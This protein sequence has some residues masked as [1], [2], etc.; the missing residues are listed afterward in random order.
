MYPHCFT[1][2][3]YNNTE[4]Q[5]TKY[6]VIYNDSCQVPDSTIDLNCKMPLRGYAYRHI[7]YLLKQAD[8]EKSKEKIGNVLFAT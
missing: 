6:K 7:N 1:R 3:C 4:I 8:T 5:N 2:L